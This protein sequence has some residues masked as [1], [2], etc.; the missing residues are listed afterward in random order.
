M[1]HPPCQNVLFRI[2][3][4]DDRIYYRS[5]CPVCA[6][7]QGGEKDLTKIPIG[8]QCRAREITETYLEEVRSSFVPEPPPPPKEN[9]TVYSKKWYRKKGVSTV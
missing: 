1:I 7:W 5:A 3:A 2:T 4:P 6:E 8:E 9:L